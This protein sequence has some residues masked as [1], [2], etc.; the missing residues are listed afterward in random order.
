MTKAKKSIKLT[1]IPDDSSD[2]ETETYDNN[3]LDNIIKVKKE[4]SEEYNNFL[5]YIIYATIIFAILS[6]PIFDQI[7][8]YAIPPAQ[9]WLILVGIKTVIFFMIYYIIYNLK[10]QKFNNE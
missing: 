10:R 4:N 2:E 5:I 1:D 7:L 9:S 3:I 6:L 8:K